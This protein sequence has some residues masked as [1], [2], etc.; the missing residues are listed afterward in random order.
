MNLENLVNEK[1][2]EIERK[3]ELRKR[4]WVEGAALAAYSFPVGIPIDMLGTGMSFGWSLV[5]RVVS[6]PINLYLGKYQG[7]WEDRVRRTFKIRED[8]SKFKKGL[9]DFVSVGSFQGALYGLITTTTKGA[10]ALY[11]WDL[12]LTEPEKILRGVLVVLGASLLIAWGYRKILDKSR[13]YFGLKGYY[14]KLE[15]EK[16]KAY[17]KQNEIQDENQKV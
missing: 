5:N 11:K 13:A 2:K 6:I 10:Q 1:D 8:S 12:S 3:V 16:T 4:K 14:E 7:S 9:A 17:K 15:S